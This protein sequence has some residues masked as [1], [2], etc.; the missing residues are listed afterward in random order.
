VDP[1]TH[2]VSPDSPLSLGAA[3]KLLVRLVAILKPN[4]ALLSCMG[5]TARTGALTNAEALRMASG[6]RL[7][8]EK[9]GPVVSGPAFLRALDRARTLLSEEPES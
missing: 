9:D 5:K 2:R 3:S 1:E 7:L 8:S 6:C 4:P